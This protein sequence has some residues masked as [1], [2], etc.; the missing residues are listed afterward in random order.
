MELKDSFKKNEIQNPIILIKQI[1]IIGFL[2]SYPNKLVGDDPIIPFLKKI[3]K[4]N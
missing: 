2:V 3:F 1:T 4:Y